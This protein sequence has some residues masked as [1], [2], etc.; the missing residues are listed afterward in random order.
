[1]NTKE[2]DLTV[3][4]E[5]KRNAE[6]Q[7]ARSK[8]KLEQAEHRMNR[9]RQS[10]NHI[11]GRKNKKRNSRLIQKGIAIETHCKETALLEP[12]EFQRLVKEI[13]SDERLV[14]KIGIITAGRREPFDQ[15]LQ[16]LHDLQMELN[17]FRKSQAKRSGKKTKHNVERIENENLSDTASKEE[18][19]NETDT[20]F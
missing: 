1:M 3:L 8:H 18:T 9:A 7:A 2:S 10:A 5:Q 20:E 6:E 19:V 4:K 13:F 14:L 11:V 12:E 15:E 17:S 16:E